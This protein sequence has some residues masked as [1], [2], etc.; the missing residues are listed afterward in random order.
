M[1][2]SDGEINRMLPTS[3]HFLQLY[4]GT[5]SVTLRHENTKAW[6]GRANV[7]DSLPKTFQWEIYNA[8]RY[9]DH[10]VGTCFGE[11]VCNSTQCTQ[12]EL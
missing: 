11:S 8:P 9:S 4:K 2:I 10:V 1:Q 5:G 6:S 3:L 7:M 12:T